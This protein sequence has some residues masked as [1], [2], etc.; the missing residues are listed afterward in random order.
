M[1]E[2]FPAEWFPISIIVIFFLGAKSFISKLEAIWKRV[3]Q[4]STAFDLF[5][6]PSLVVTVIF[7]LVTS[8]KNC[9]KSRKK[10]FTTTIGF[11]DPRFLVI[12]KMHS[13]VGFLLRKLLFLDTF[14]FK[15][16]DHISYQKRIS[17]YITQMRQMI[18]DD[19]KEGKDNT[20]SYT[21][22]SIMT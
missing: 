20:D 4:L 22:K 7:T 3:V 2:L 17:S 10:C 11:Y 9:W 19:K 6:Q 5:N 8:A 15:N 16:S 18:A 12:L 14:L 21:T 13:G 1:K